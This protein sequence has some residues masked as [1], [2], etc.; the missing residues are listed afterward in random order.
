MNHL[1]I[2]EAYS[3]FEKTNLYTPIT[4]PEYSSYF[5][6]NQIQKFNRS[7][8][9]YLL[10]F[11]EEY[12]DTARFG[13]LGNLGDTEPRNIGSFEFEFDTGYNRTPENLITK[14]RLR[15]NRKVIGNVF[16][17]NDDWFLIA[18]FNGYYT[19]C[20]QIYGLVEALKSYFDSRIN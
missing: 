19:K 14:L 10:N 13:F 12:I 2:F 18:Y 15:Y 11:L 9:E 4:Y 1:K 17:T 3:P 16:K 8:K 5:E 7:D 6:N 20:D